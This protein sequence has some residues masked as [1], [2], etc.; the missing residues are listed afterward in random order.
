MATPDEKSTSATTEAQPDEFHNWIEFAFGGAFVQGD[1]AQFEQNHRVP[2]DQV[3]GGIQDLHVE[4]SIGKDVQF[5]LDGHAIFDT[6]DYGLKLQLSK[7]KLGYLQ[8]GYD[9]FRSWYDGN[10]GFFPPNG[11]FF[12]PAHP[13]MHIDRG[14][15]WVE[16]G[17][18]APDLP[19][20]TVRYSHEFRQGMKDSTIWGDTNLTGIEGATRKIAPAFRSIDETRDTFTFDAT[21]NFGKTDLLLGM[22]Y[23]HDNNDYSLNMIRGAGQLPPLVAAPGAQRFITQHQKDDVDLFSGH[24]ITEMRFSDTFWFT[25][26]YSYTTMTNDLSGTRLP[27]IT[28]DAPFG[29]PIP[30]LGQR[31]HSFI[32]LAG[33]AQ[34]D[35]HIV[36]ANLYWVPAKDVTLLGGFRYTHENRDSDSVFLAVEPE[37]NVPPFSETNPEG[38]FHLGTP[39]PAAG[40]RSSDYDRFAQNI[41]LRLTG[42]PDWLFYVRGEWEE[43]YGHVDEFHTDEE[44]PLDKDTHQL[45]QKYTLGANW[46]PLMRLNFSGQ[47][48]HKISSYGDDLMTGVFPR[49]HNQDWNTDDLNLRITFRPKLPASCGSLS[50]VTRYDFMRTVIDTQWFFEGELFDEEQTGEITKHVISESINWSPLARL[51]FQTDFSYVWDRTDTPASSILFDPNT[52]PSVLDFEN[53]YWTLT[54]SAGFIIDDKTDVRA[55]YS[56]Y[57]ADDYVDNSLASV[58]YGAGARE[59]I[60]SATLTRQLTKQVRLQLSYT[61][62]DYTDQ[63]SGG[64]NNY[65]AHSIFSSL[66]FAF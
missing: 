31:D 62:Y 9:E 41:E 6:N 30:T 24:A 51:Y 38:G 7:A 46:Y 32:N 15:V 54:A 13:E 59:H 50:L 8:I 20:I 4:Q 66:R 57:R 36:N 61:F 5:S 12:P 40:A 60:A 16:L 63:T 35:E 11:Q 34:V 2:A 49:I 42:L 10:G 48:Y 17:L 27:G 44:E 14:D 52:I 47:F 21:K 64:H 3:F 37:A 39:E 28:F 1:E 65:R 56:Y 55:S 45:N 25:T 19:E 18:R 26:G 33:T 29:E 58:P 23:E 22:R 53:D 43:E